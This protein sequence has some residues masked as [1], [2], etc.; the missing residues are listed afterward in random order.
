MTTIMLADAHL[1]LHRMQV[2]SSSS[3][4]KRMRRLT[5]NSLL[6]VLLALFLTPA[7]LLADSQ[8]LC[9]RRAGMHHCDSTD[10]SVAAENKTET[11]LNRNSACPMRYCATTTQAKLGMAGAQTSVYQPRPAD[12][13]TGKI[14]V[15]VAK[16][17]S[18]ELKDRSPP[19]FS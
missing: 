4:L 19:L 2:Y 3:P 17:L 6:L 14:L 7:A 13:L 16:A 9:C 15:H 5:A 12:F 1:Y 10:G 18:S 8:R 11:S